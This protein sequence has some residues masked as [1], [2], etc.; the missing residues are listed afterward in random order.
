M[1]SRVIGLLAASLICSTLTGRAHAETTITVLDTYP[2]GD[3]IVLGL[4]QYYYVRIAYSTDTPVH[5]WVNPYFHGKPASAGSNT[6]GEYTGVGEAFGWFFLSKPGAEVDEVR[7]AVGD[8]SY[9]RTPVLATLHVHVV[10]GT[11]RAVGLEPAWVVSM[12]QQAAEDQRRDYEARQRAP[13]G[14]GTFADVAIFGGFML[15]MAAFGIGAIV[16]PIRALRRWQGAWRY[17][18]LV[19]V[20]P[21][22]FVV[23][24]IVFDVSRDPT[25]HNLWP[26]E[27]VQVGLLSLILLGGLGIARRAAGASRA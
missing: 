22:A 7:I 19:A 13:S 17:A 5:I 25:S 15:V 11:A 27:I 1:R 6:S 12:K 23:L 21:I 18:A 9:E 4:N 20:A 2:A 24:R 14:G 8:G 10:S 16:M 26:F 3:E